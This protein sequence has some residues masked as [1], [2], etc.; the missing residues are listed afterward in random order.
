MSKAEALR[1]RLKA[2]PRGQAG[3][4]DFEDICIDTLRYLFVPPLKEPKVQA[5]TIFGTERRDAMFP[6]WVLDHASNWGMLREEFSAK[7]IVCEF[8]NYE[9]E[10]G[11]EEAVQAGGYLHDHIGKL[12]FMICSKLPNQGAHAKRNIIYREDKKLVLF[13]TVEHLV[14]MIAYR[15]LGEDPSFV[16]MDLIDAFRMEYQ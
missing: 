8:K 6:N 2:C 11:Q 3:W 16:I 10:I 9:A 14:E 1:Q 5:R 15:E 7:I 4:R 13:I 12:G